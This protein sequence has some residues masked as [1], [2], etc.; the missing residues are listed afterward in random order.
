MSAQTSHPEDGVTSRSILRKLDLTRLVADHEMVRRIGIGA[1][2]EVWLARSVT[3]TFRAVKVVLR[4]RFDHE[5]SYAREFAGLKKFEP[6]SRA[7][8]ALVDILQVGRNDAAGYFYCVMELADTAAPEES[9]Y[10]PLTLAEHIRRH[11]RLRPLD[12]AR[13]GTVIAEGLAL[14]DQIGR[15]HV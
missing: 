2:G 3:G 14:N 11:G 4:E 10:V 15:E 13:V 9:S 7:H 8:D 6:V 5:R 12:C 1:Y